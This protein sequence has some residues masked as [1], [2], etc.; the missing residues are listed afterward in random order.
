M[1][2]L[3]VIPEVNIS[4]TVRFGAYPTRTFYIDKTT[5]RIVRRTDGIEAITQAVDVILNT[6]RYGYRIYS[7]RF[8][9]ELTGLIGRDYPYVITQIRRRVTEAL[10]MDDRITSVEDFKFT[11]GDNQDITVKFTVRSIFGRFAAEW[12]VTPRYD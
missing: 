2:T 7:P 6:E 4:G 8:G 11:M 3:P 5:R 10:M 1:A 9:S 12:T